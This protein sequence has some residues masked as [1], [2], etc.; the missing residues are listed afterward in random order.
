MLGDQGARRQ[1]P[2]RAEADPAAG[3]VRDGHRAPREL[4]QAG[5]AG[6]GCGWWRWGLFPLRRLRQLPAPAPR[7]RRGKVVLGGGR[8]SRPRRRRRARRRRRRRRHRPPSRRPA[9]TTPP[10]RPP[11]RRGAGAC[12]LRAGG[13]AGARGAEGV[14]AG[15]R[16]HLESHG[17]GRAA[18]TG[19]PPPPSRAPRPSGPAAALPRKGEPHTFFTTGLAAP[20]APRYARG[21]RR[22]RRLGRLRRGGCSV[23]SGSRRV[24]WR[25]LAQAWRRRAVREGA[26]DARRAAPSRSLTATS[27]A[28]TSSS[29]VVDARRARE[30]TGSAAG[31]QAPGDGLA[32]ASPD[33]GGAAAAAAAGLRRIVAPRLGRHPTIRTGGIYVVIRRPTAGSTT[34]RRGRGCGHGGEGG[35]RRLMA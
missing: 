20:E 11:S 3:G 19:C 4:R 32:A 7:R 28:A 35:A 9:S 23:I 12:I 31:G 14:G 27:R 26:L 30:A 13:R 24:S 6:D 2:A 22:R 29:I 21:R 18:T 5:G 1:P 25:P 16:H 33:V 34:Q 8:R 10:R 17:R 15:H